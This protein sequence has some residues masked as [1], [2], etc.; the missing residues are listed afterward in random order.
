M[1]TAQYDLCVKSE[2][3]PDRRPR[4]AIVSDTAMAVRKDQRVALAPVVR[5]ISAFSDA[6]RITWLGFDR[7]ELATGHAMMVV[8]DSVACIPLAAV[9]GA[10][11]WSK[12][13]IVASLPSMS[14]RVLRAV[15]S[16][17]IVHTRGPSVPAFL[18]VLFSFVLRRPIW[19]HKYAGNWGQQN[20]PRSYG[21]QRWLLHRAV[22]CVVTINGQWPNQLAHCKSVA[23]PCLSSEERAIGEDCVATKQYSGPLTA[24]FVGRVEQAKGI[25]RVLDAIEAAGDRVARLLVV[26]DG[27]LTLQYEADCRKR[28]LP[29]TFLGALDFDQLR[30]VYVTSHVLL[31]PSDAEGFPKVIAEAWNYGCV[32]L[33][34]DV[35]AIPFYV[36]EDNGFVWSAASG[37]TYSDWIRD[38]DLSEDTLARKAKSGFSS[39][40]PFTFD[41][42]V[43][44]INDVLFTEARAESG[45]SDEARPG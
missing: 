20:P 13:R 28:S 17:D 18:A 40:A 10:S 12:I 4:L 41:A 32:P 1:T 44:E 6:Y 25:E 26:G 38:R 24:C 3:H 5:E 7:P 45:R 33:V 23:N 42:F 2:I 11:L 31:L 35:G 39:T 15:R 14:W 30:D 36:H 8:P 27:D 37:V 16:A 19:W 22:H 29:V 34:S 9:G 43:R 21:V